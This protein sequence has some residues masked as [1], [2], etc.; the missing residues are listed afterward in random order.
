MIS[1]AIKK[2]Y[3]NTPYVVKGDEWESLDGTVFD[4]IAIINEKAKMEYLFDL[5]KYK[6]NR[7]REYPPYSDYL[8]GVVKG[9]QDQIDE[10]V[11]ACQAVKEK[12]PKTEMDEVELTNR[13][14]QALHDYQL[15]EYTKAQERLAQYQVASGREEETEEVVVGQEWNEETAGMVDVTETQITVSAI[16]PVPATVEQITYDEDGVSTTTEIENPVI[17]KD[18]AERAAAQAIVDATPQSVIDQ[19]NS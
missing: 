8:D 15:T 10:Y 12:Y 16:Q 13:Q 9:D 6:E 4:D 11:A 5:E 1:E 3:P 17:T 2:L 19:Y 7:A 18:N 14:R